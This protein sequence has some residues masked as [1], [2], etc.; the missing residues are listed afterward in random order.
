[1]HRK[2]HLLSSLAREES[3]ALKGCFTPPLDC[4]TLHIV[5]ETGRMQSLNEYLLNLPCLRPQV[6]VRLDG[7]LD[8]EPN[9][10]LRKSSSSK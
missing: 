7:T 3:E 5:A 1:M 6:C 9:T 2:P 10:R 4:T 8:R